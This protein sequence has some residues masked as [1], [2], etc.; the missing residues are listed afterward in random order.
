[1][2]EILDFR[3][4]GL[5]FKSYQ[6]CNCWLHNPQLNNIN[7]CVDWNSVTLNVSMLINI[8]WSL[9]GFNPITSNQEC[10]KLTTPP[11]IHGRKCYKHNEPCLEFNLTAVWT[12]LPQKYFPKL[13]TCGINSFGLF[14]AFKGLEKI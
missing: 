1:M 13:C 2:G 9:A 5:G 7:S 14:C 3:V 10:V 11:Q 4:K 6:R 8:P 12:T